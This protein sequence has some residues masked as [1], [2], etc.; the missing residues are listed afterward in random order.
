MAEQKLT[1][2]IGANT[3]EFDEKLKGTNK[4]VQEFGEGLGT[5]AAA[6]AAAAGAIAILTDWFKKTEAG[7]DMLNTTMI[8]SRQLLTDL[9]MKQETHLMQ[10]IQLADR[11]NKIRQGDRYDLVKEA[12]LNRDIRKYRLEAYSGEAS[13]QE[14]IIAQTKAI[15]KQKELE[16]YRKA[17]LF[18][19]LK[20]VEDRLK[21][22]QINTELLDRQ[23]QLMAAIFNADESESLRMVSYLNGLL[24]EAKTRAFELADAFTAIKEEAIQIDNMPINFFGTTTL[25]A[26]S[27]KQ[28]DN[29]LAPSPKLTEVTKGLTDQQE[30]LLGLSDTFA[31]FFSDVNLGFQGMIDGVI[32]GI[33]RLVMELMAKAAFMAILSL[34]FPASAVPFTLK[35]ILGGNAATLVGGSTVLSTVGTGG[36]FSA[37]NNVTG[38]RLIAGINGKELRIVLSRS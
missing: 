32:T 35:N 9:I 13:I 19:E 22:D 12:Q 7:V 31:G 37:M 8:V 14:K 16:A 28:A 27:F 10:S 3:K 11:A 23:A 2:N 4:G 24:K 34:I 26:P 36:G 18:E 17:D 25:K 21:L 38:E 1:V 33:K 6:G 15:E 30:A 5:I 20:L 29:I